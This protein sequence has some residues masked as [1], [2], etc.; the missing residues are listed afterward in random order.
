[1]TL[2]KLAATGLAIAALALPA[3]SK[4]QEAKPGE[5]KIPGTNTTLKLNGFVEVDV[6][7]D[8]DGAIED[9]RSTDW[10][11]L[12]IFQPLDEPGG[13]QSFSG[14][15]PKKQLYIT[16]RTSRVGFTTST[17]TNYG[18]LNVR[19]EADFNSPSPDN[20]SSELTTGGNTFRMRH[21]YGEFGGLL[22]GQTW[23]NF[24]DLGSLPDTV[25]FN[26][27]GA[28]ALTR[29]P[30]IRYAFKL[31]APSLA[32]ALENPQSRV[33]G[34]AEGNSTQ[35]L[36][37]RYPDITANFTM[38]FSAGHFNLRG[39]VHEYR[40]RT[41]ASTAP[42]GAEDSVWGWGVGASGSL[43]LGKNDTFVW[44]VQGGDGIGR[45]MFQTIFQ[46]GTLVGTEIETWK[47][48]AYHV[49]LT[50]AW[51]SS[52]RSNLVFTQ[53]F[54]E[55]NDAAAAVLGDIANKR[56]DVAFVNT[57]W[58][59]LKGVEFGLE[60]AYGRRTVFDAGLASAGIALSNNEGT[61]HRANALAR[62]SFF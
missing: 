6:T 40:S 57:F 23:S 25:D 38:P 47:A 61:Q 49:G 30:M 12:M 16:P 11:S 39:V 10:A 27:H 56:V 9:I 36:Y 4:A 42:G 54:I 60:Y 14:E 22:I 45:Y 3:A 20:F 33:I 8:F 13:T 26:P 34:T 5:F 41:V 1:M 53:T 48:V 50:H 52:V 46:G 17:P 32:V 15:R 28:F 59:P 55:G 44:S 62:Y 37:D 29:Q 2:S 51:N 7:Y 24:M 43:K 21:A 31:G 58:S 35:R 18:A 19:V